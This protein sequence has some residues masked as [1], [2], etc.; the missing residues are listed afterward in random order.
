MKL[1]KY[2]EPKFFDI[3]VRVPRNAHF[4]NRMSA[5][6]VAA[7]V[8]VEATSVATD[9]AP[10]AK[11]RKGRARGTGPSRPKP[12]KA[13]LSLREHAHYARL[14]IALKQG[15]RINAPVVLADFCKPLLPIDDKDVTGD[16]LDESE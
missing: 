6:P 11:A 15:A 7:S 1:N 5:A 14:K 2:V 3:F 12:L 4:V 10:V 9:A 8:V 13:L 16:G